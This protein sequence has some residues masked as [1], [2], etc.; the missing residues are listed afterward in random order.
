MPIASGRAA[1]FACGSILNPTG[2]IAT[3]SPR[4]IKSAS[5][6]LAI[7]PKLIRDP[8]HADTDVVNALAGASL[9]G[10]APS[11]VPRAYIKDCRAIAVASYRF[12]MLP[13][14]DRSAGAEHKAASGPCQCSAGD[15]ECAWPTGR[16]R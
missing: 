8:Q 15:N 7:A 5:S 1:G 13:G 4:S 11:I 3:I 2:G 10:S 6:G 16:S 14:R 9:S 12:Y